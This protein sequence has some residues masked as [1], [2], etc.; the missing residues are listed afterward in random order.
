MKV[1]CRPTRPLIHPHIVDHH[2]I[3][4]VTA[5]HGAAQRPTDGQVQDQ[6]HRAG[7]RPI[8][9]CGV[10]GLVVC[11]VGVVAVGIH[12]KADVVL[13][14]PDLVGME[15]GNWRAQGRDAFFLGVAVSPCLRH[16]LGIVLTFEMKR[17]LRLLGVEVGRRPFHDVDFAGIGPLTLTQQPGCRP[18][19]LPHR[20]LGPQ[21]DVGVRS[22]IGHRLQTGRGDAAAGL[23]GCDVQGP[24]L[25][26]SVVD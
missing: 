11:V 17:R 5:G 14:P 9:R 23:V 15:F 25:G 6:I 12:A 26:V 3:V 16:V 18:G 10:S 8:G 1:S 21:F 24:I 4:K 7:E 22:D 19:T 20:D 13:G 2:L